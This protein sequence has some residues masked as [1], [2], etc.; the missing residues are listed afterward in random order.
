MPP[1]AQP[2]K[3]SFVAQPGKHDVICYQ[4]AKGQDIIADGG[5]AVPEVEQ[6]ATKEANRFCPHLGPITNPTLE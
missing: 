4:E 6:K 2:W 3:D 1:K 5:A